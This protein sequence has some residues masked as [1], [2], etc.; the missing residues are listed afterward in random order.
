MAWIKRIKKKLTTCGKIF[1]RFYALSKSFG[2]VPAFCIVALPYL[3]S[4]QCHD[5]MGRRFLDCWD[6]NLANK[7]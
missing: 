1:K 3:K 4:V 2:I 6:S 5:M 7:R